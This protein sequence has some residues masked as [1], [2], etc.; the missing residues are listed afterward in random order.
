MHRKCQTG[1]VDGGK[2]LARLLQRNLNPG[3]LSY[4]Y[5][6]KLVVLMY[7]S[8]RWLFVDFLLVSMI[9]FEKKLKVLRNQFFNTRRHIQEMV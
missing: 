4:R 9:N 1:S 8:S 3:S 6:L 5:C 7:F 2:D